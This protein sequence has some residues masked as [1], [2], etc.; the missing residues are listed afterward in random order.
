MT[1]TRHRRRPNRQRRAVRW[2]AILGGATL[3]LAAVSGAAS[4]IKAIRR[5]QAAR[6]WL[7]VA[8][9]HQAQQRWLEAAQAVE[10]YLNMEPAADNQ[11]VRLA[12]LYS[13]GAETADQRERAIDLL[14]RAL[15]VS[16]HE[17]R[18]PLRLSLAEL[19]LA[20]ERWSE[21]QIQAQQII[22]AHPQ[23]PNALRI[24]ALALLQQYKRGE[25]DRTVSRNLPIVA[26]LD[27]ARRANRCDVELAELTALAYRDLE[28]GVSA[29]VSVA[30]RE[31]LA[32]ACL[33]ELVEAAPG[34]PDA[35]LA[36]YRYRL[37]LGH[38]DADADLEA[39]LT[40]GAD[41]RSTLLT[42]ARAARSK[43]EFVTAA[44]LYRSALDCDPTTSTPALYLELGEALLAAGERAEALTVWRRGLEKH[45]EAQILL[46][47]KLADAH[48][49]AGEWRDAQQCISAVDQALWDWAASDDDL[50][51]V[52]RD[53][54]LRRGTLLARQGDTAAAKE[55]F[56]HA[57][58]L[59]E[60]LGGSSPQTALAWRR[61]GELHSRSGE[62]AAA[63]AAFDYACHEQPQ[64]AELWLLA[65]EAHLQAEHIDLTIDRALQA[66]RRDSS[67]R[68]QAIL[69]RAR[70]AK[71]LQ[72]GSAGDCTWPTLPAI[73][74]IL[75]SQSGDA[76]E[77]SKMRPLPFDA[78]VILSQ[79]QAQRGEHALAQEL[80]LR[81]V[82]ACSDAERAG[83]DRELAA[84]ALNRGDFSEALALLS[85]FCGDAPDNKA[86]RTLTAEIS[87]DNARRQREQEANTFLP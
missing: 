59:Q 63:A 8:D 4:H 15:G 31:Q 79:V 85:R 5:Q 45:P 82:P 12:R 26:W 39:A 23:D 51:A 7:Q 44:R 28:L 6:Q 29:D 56:Q 18:L 48:L 86:L 74:D 71:S 80:L 73:Q 2:L 54:C 46:Q 83:I 36:R 66:I 20:S 32:D 64:A 10:A 35:Y 62:W 75:L 58:T 27:E 87:V 69:A 3:A 47:G 14:Y 37:H 38:A 55:Q 13:M 33:N 16:P 1:S 61:L 40:S 78:A 43:S 72:P 65:A 34:H 77:S 81:A 68:A 50:L 41:H 84:H 53:Q 11:R 76:A 30:T 17:Q 19:L 9:E 70:L 57:I 67:A 52:S 60:Q 22:E 21:A 24:R 42:A 25:L 49:A